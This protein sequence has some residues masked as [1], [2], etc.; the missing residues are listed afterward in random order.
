[1]DKAKPILVVDDSNAARM[2]ICSI[3]ESEGYKTI[4]ANNGVVALKMISEMEPSLLFLDLLMPEMDGIDVLKYMK[5][6][7]ISIPTII[8]TA[9]IQEEVKQEC[10][11]LGAVGFLNKP[12]KTQVIIDS[13]L[14]HYK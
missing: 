5:E 10:F 9:D 14:N 7:S 11:D 1:M 4:Q 13:I 2:Q 8:L 6:K 3:I 12:F